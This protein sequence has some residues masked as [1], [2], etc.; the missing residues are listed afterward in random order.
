MEEARELRHELRSPVNDL[1]GYAVQLLEEEEGSTEA[2]QKMLGAVVTQARQVLE[3]IPSMLAPDGKPS[4]GVARLRVLGEQLN[5]GTQTLS[6][7]IGELPA[8]DMQR[9]CSAAF[10]LG[11]FAARLGQVCSAKTKDKG[12]AS[13]ASRGQLGMKLVVDDGE[14]YREVRG[15]RL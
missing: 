14:A 10:G 2:Q 1:I 3:L 13:V 9:L 6:K 7:N 4:D 15:S 12:D 5:A 8:A 11:E